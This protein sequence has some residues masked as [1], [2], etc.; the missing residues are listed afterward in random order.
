MEKKSF[1]MTGYVERSTCNC[2][3]ISNNCFWQDGGFG[4]SNYLSH[5]HRDIERYLDELSGAGHGE[6]GEPCD[7]KVTVTIEKLGKHDHRLMNRRS[8]SGLGFQ[9]NSELKKQIVKVEEPTETIVLNGDNE[10][11]TYEE[12]KNRVKNMRRELAVTFLQDMHD[13]LLLVQR[14]GD[15]S[16]LD[17]LME[18]LTQVI[19]R[20]DT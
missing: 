20:D 10:F 1:V 5:L 16:K 17:E 18:S 13:K 4:G 8:F 3:C 9:D 12:R 7:V 11:G 6:R 14:S 19:E 2:G 15:F